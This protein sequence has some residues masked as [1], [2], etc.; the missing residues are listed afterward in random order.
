MTREDFY[1]DSR[2]GVNK[3]H[4]VR[5]IPAGDPVAVLQIIHGMCE[6]VDR[7]EDFAKYM[8]EKGFLVTAND[9]LGHGKSIV[10]NCP[11]YFTDKNP[12]NVVIRDVHRLKKLTEEKYNHKPYF[13]LGHSMG[14]FILRNYLFRYGKGIT[15]AIVMG[16]GMEPHVK[17]LS[18]EMLSS[19]GCLF[20][21]A[22]SH[23]LFITKQG[24]GTYLKKI[25]NPRTQSDWLTKREDIVDKYI[26]DPLSGFLFT[27]NGY[28]TLSELLLPLYKKK[29]IEKIPVTLPVLIVSGTEDPVGEYGKAPKALYESFKKTGMQKVTLKLYEGDRHEVLNETDNE[30]VYSDIYT[31]ITENK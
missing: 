27:N 7:Y 15:G 5:W 19:L 16:T 6:H 23:N 17:I 31:W 4:A 13:V 8:C 29:N 18:M 30:T 14:S 24:F 22:K 26:A 25:D 3:I 11:G 2:D 20:G 12:A 10:D 1:F 28:K 21:K 9:H